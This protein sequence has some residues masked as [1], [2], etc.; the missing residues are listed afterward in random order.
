MVVTAVLTGVR[1][2]P[3]ISQA[4]HNTS[5][6]TLVTLKVSL[7]VLSLFSLFFVFGCHIFQLKPQT[8]VVE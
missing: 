8:G 5:E 7:K 2:K 6:T 4:T 3:S 1:Q